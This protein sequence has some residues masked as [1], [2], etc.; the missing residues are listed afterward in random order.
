M[1]AVAISKMNDYS[2]YLVNFGIFPPPS[3]LLSL[4]KD[5]EGL[6]GGEREG[7]RGTDNDVRK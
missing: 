1:T 5:K 7:S 3:L 2:L 4:T 6:Y